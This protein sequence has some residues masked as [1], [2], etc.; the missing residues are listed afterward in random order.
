MKKI[1]FLSLILAG[2]AG[3]GMAQTSFNVESLPTNVGGKPEFKRMFEQEL[4]YPKNALAHNVDGKVTI[5][6]T[7]KKDSS[8]AD[9]VITESPAITLQ[10]NPDKLAQPAM[11]AAMKSAKELEAEALRLFKFYE[12][13]PAVKSGAYVSTKWNVTFDFESGKYDKICKERGF[14]QVKYLPKMQVDSSFKVYT[15]ADQMPMYQKGNF[16]LQDFI[17]ANLEYPRQAQLSNI[18]GTVML[19]FTVEPSG[20]P[21]NIGVIKSVGGGCD[22]EA[23]RII[24]MIKWYPAKIGDKLVRGRMTFPIYFVLNDDFKDNSA[25]E[26]K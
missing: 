7:I 20:L 22:Q 14:K 2:F 11:I 17:K 15:V 24:E 10:S 13:V 16:A 1:I 26:Q 12:W 5:S 9:V 4:V 18:Q 25:G 8:T 21:T 23:I 6:F 3:N 19:S